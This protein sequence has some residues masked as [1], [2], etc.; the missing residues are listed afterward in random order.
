MACSVAPRHASAFGV[1]FVVLRDARVEVPAVVIEAHR[2]VGD[3]RLHFGGGLLFQVVEADHHVGHL[4]AG[5]VDVVLHLHPVPPRAQHAHERVAQHGIAQV[6]DVRRLVGIDVGVL[7]DDLFAGRLRGSSLSPRKQGGAVGAAVEPH[8]DVAVA[9]HLHGRDARDGA[10]L[11]GQFGGDLLRRLAQLL[12]ELER[13]GHG[14]FAEIALPRLLDG[15]GQIDAVARLNV[16]TEG[17]R[18]LF[19]NGMEHGELRV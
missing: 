6:A 8:V 10:D 18:N 16:R 17:A 7:D 1:V 13:G 2:R 9:G 5:V 15:E 14:H 3:Q 4:H 11:V 19:F 12:G